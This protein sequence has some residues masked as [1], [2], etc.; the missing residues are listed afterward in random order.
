MSPIG[1]PEASLRCDHCNNRIEKTPGFIDNVSEP[2][3]MSVGEISLER[4]GFDGI[5]GQNRK[6]ERMTAERVLVRSHNPA[7]GFLDRL[8]HLRGSARR[9]IQPA[10]SGAQTLRAG[11]G[12][13][14]S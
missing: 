9:L 14:R 13:A 1:G 11:F 10:F 7:A 5:D 12:F 2:F 6:Q 8:R 3:V 4:G